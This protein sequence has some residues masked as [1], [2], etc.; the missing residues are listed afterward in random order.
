MS[1]LDYL[2][3]VQEFSSKNTSRLQVASLHRILM[4]KG[5][6]QDGQLVLDWGGGRYDITKEYVE[7]NK[8][9]TFLIYDPFNRSKEHNEN[10]LSI[11]EEN[12]GADIITL[13]NVLNVI[14]EKEVRID[15][16][17]EIK[18]YLNG[19]LYISVYE[20]PKSSNY[21]ETDEWVGQQT[22]DGWQNCQP[23]SYYIPEVEQIFLNV[24]KK[25]SILIAG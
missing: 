15:L 1:I 9:I 10:V 12:G 19:N 7:S 22:K 4:Q 13:A 5:I 16:L 11:V 6:Y 25:G 3:E 23:L 2:I 14:K 20:A 24:I 18:N 8:N 21:K 17:K